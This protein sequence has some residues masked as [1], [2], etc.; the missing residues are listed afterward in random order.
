MSADGSAPSPLSQGPVHVPQRAFPAVASSVF[1]FY[2]AHQNIL[3]LLPITPRPGGKEHPGFPWFVV[4]SVVI[5]QDQCFAPDDR[6][7]SISLIVSDHTNLT[8]SRPKST[9]TVLAAAFQTEPGF[10]V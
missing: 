9:G 8:T 10:N 3:E 2:A 1:S 4:T 6:F 7:L 5:L